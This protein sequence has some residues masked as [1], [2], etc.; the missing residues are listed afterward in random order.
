VI[1]GHVV[2]AKVREKEEAKHRY[3]AAAG[4][5]ATVYSDKK[6]DAISLKIGNLLPG[7]SATINF[8]VIEDLEIVGGAY[9]YTMPAFPDYR[10][11]N[12]KRFPYDFA[13]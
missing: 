11:H 13:Y 6:K 12:F 9:A 2:E 10:K 8:S 7:E 3:D 4:G 5:H 1:G